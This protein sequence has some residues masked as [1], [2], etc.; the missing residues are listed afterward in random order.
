MK[1]KN[2]PLYRFQQ[3]KLAIR[4]PSHPV[5]TKELTLHLNS[6][7]L[8]LFRKLQP[9][10]QWHAFLV[11]R[12]LK[13]KGCTDA[14]LLSAALLH[15]IGKILFPLNVWDRVMIVLA[16][17]IFPDQ[18]KKWGGKSPQGFFKQF[19]VA[20]QHADWGADLVSKTGASPELVDLIL[21]HEQKSNENPTSHQDHLLLELQQADNAY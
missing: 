18:A 17:Q 9:S 14:N 12:T 19:V 15:D 1:T 11:Y 5:P 2:N 3:F 21:R 4:P 10:E 13:D 16:N 6:M 7:Q 8:T 20:H